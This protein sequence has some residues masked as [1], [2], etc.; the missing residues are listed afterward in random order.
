M[1]NELTKVNL[2]ALVDDILEDHEPADEQGY[3]ETAPPLTYCRLR[4]NDL[5]DDQTGK[6]LRARGSFLFGATKEPIEDDFNT[7]QGILIGSG[8]VYTR[9]ENPDDKQPACGSYNLV[10]AEEWGYRDV[11]DGTPRACRTCEFRRGGVNFNGD[12]IRNCKDNL[13]FFLW[14]VRRQELICFQAG[15]SAYRPWALF[16]KQTLREFQARA[17]K[18]TPGGTVPTEFPWIRV[19]LEISPVWVAEKG[20]YYV[21]DFLVI[22]KVDRETLPMLR[23]V[24]STM[25][26]R[27]EATK[28]AAAQGATMDGTDAM[29]TGD[30]SNIPPGGARPSRPTGRDVSKG[31]AAPPRST[32]PKGPP[33]DESGDPGPGGPGADELPF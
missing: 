1:G 14:E 4:Q 26:D 19:V 25:A 9:F 24:R 10:S 29:G 23:Q 7:L 32:A 27:I 18:K 5:A 2:P 31:A 28:Q 30:D 12:T 15:P 8:E 20:G 33:P 16:H 11:R 6:T 22:D 3:V 21:P 17:A 13:Q